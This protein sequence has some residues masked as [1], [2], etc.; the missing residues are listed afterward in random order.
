[1]GARPGWTGHGEGRPKRGEALAE[2]A[3]EER[4]GR[5]E[6]PAEEAEREA[7][8]GEALGS[9][10]GERRPGEGKCPGS[11]GAWRCS[12]AMSSLTLLRAL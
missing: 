8:R 9:R 10:P 7:R 11:G 4:P 1:M 6:A 12:E 5:G 3:Q 2:Q